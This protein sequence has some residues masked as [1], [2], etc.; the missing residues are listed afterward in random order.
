MHMESY[1]VVSYTVLVAF[2]HNRLL[3]FTTTP[4]PPHSTPLPPHSYV[5]RAL[6]VQDDMAHTS[7]RFGLGRFTTVDEV[8]TVNTHLLAVVKHA[9]GGNERTV[10]SHTRVTLTHT[11]NPLA[12]P[13]P[14][15]HPHRVLCL[16][17][18]VLLRL[19]HSPFL[20]G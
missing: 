5:L 11:R 7:L 9:V 3:T 13:P 2:S 6:G 4:P 10:P 12:P 18:R 16:L 8:S 20:S 14:R 19:L 17:P 15:I 1:G